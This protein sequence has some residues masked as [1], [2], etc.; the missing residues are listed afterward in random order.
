MPTPEQTLQTL[1]RLDP[2]F[3]G[4]AAAIAPGLAGRLHTLPPGLAEDTIALLQAERPELAAWLDVRATVP[5]DKLNIDPLT[6]VGTLAAIM[7]LL[8]AHI[9]IESNSFYFEHKPMDSE[10]VKK[11]LDVLKNMMR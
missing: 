6:T 7:F 10:L 5:P 2:D 4:F 8:R 11:V 3:P 9:K 1:A